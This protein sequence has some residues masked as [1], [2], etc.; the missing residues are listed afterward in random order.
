MK[1]KQADRPNIEDCELACQKAIGRFFNRYFGLETIDPDIGTFE[2]KFNLDAAQRG[3]YKLAITATWL[4]VK[5]QATELHVSKKVRLARPVPKSRA[6]LSKNGKP[7]PVK[8]GRPIDLKVLEA[9]AKELT[10]QA[11]AEFAA[12]KPFRKWLPKK[13]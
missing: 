11:V 1:L 3:W 2:I 4:P 9:R 7:K 12:Y 10:D 8:G 6:K 5:G 13:V